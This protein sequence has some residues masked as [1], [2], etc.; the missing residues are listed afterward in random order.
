MTNPAEP[1][2]NIEKHPH[3]VSGSSSIDWHYYRSRESYM[4]PVVRT[5][6]LKGML[7][8][9]EEHK[10]DMADKLLEG[11]S[12]NKKYYFDT[13]NWTNFIDAHQIAWN[14]H[15]YFPETTLYDW[16]TIGANVAK[17]QTAKIFE[18]VIPFISLKY[19]YSMVPLINRNFNDT[20]VCEAVTTRNGHADYTLTVDKR[21]A[22]IDHGYL[23]H[24]FAGIVAM[25]PTAK[26]MEPATFRILYCQSKLKNI[27]NYLYHRYGLSYNQKQDGVYVEGQKIAA[28]IRLFSERI[29]GKEVLGES[30]EL[31]YD[32]H[33]GFVLLDD[34]Y[35]EG[36][37][38][39]KKGEIYDA[40]YTR[41]QFDWP[42][43]T[44]KKYFSHIFKPQSSHTALFQDVSKE[45]QLSEKRFRDAD[46]ARKQAEKAEN[47]LHRYAE[48]LEVLVEKRT[49]EIKKTHEKLIE[50]EKR[51]LEKQI[52]GGFAHEIRNA[53]TGAQIELHAI[54]GNDKQSTPAAIKKEATSVSQHLNLLPEL[55]NFPTAF[56]DGNLSPKMKSI[57]EN[58]EKLKTVLTNIS[59]K[60]ERGID[61]TTQLRDYTKL[62]DIVA[63]S[64][65]IDL[66]PLINS[67]KA[68]YSNV[69][70]EK[71]IDF[72]FSGLNTALVQGNAAHFD[73][74]FCSLIDNSID[75]LSEVQRDDKYL[76]IELTKHYLEVPESFN[77]LIKD[78]GIGMDKDT[79]KNLFSPFFTTK[80]SSSTGLSMSI[81]RRLL[82]LYQ[83]HIKVQSISG[84]GSSITITFCPPSSC[85]TNKSSI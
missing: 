18:T 56:I 84:Q 42:K 36:V 50:A 4:K 75:A 46:A 66:T 68:K 27:I 71:N 2:I 1:S 53:L 73:L 47:E 19:M 11:L 63:G 6:T 3:P 12:F 60:I 72:R 62:S 33:N 57:M 83:S 81:V 45:L 70:K 54:N 59:Q 24:H 67:Y 14:I 8:Y 29:K 61:I 40:P 79:L 9:F 65:E 35:V 16:F 64:S 25:I 5:V 82:D 17:D 39:L 28:P 21:F 55:Y 37:Q 10:G 78:N 85:Y 44:A 41:I 31:N 15:E 74:I 7:L 77:V 22:M 80:Q 52:T 76:S 69:C 34:L 32:H 48:Q 20:I 43:K 23:F 13:S 38:L 49:S 51:V 30:Y 58:S 26:N